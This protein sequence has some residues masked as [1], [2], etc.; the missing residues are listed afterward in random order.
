MRLTLAG[1]NGQETFDAARVI[2]TVPFTALRNIEISPALPPA[3]QRMIDELPYTQIAKTFVLTQ[4]RFWQDDVDFSILFS[5]SRF[6][7]L[8]NL[9]RDRTD[10][11]GLLL[12]WINGDGLAEFSAMSSDAHTDAVVEWLRTLWPD[13]ADQ[14]VDGVTVNWGNTY[15]GGAYAHFAPGQ[16]QAFATEIPKP[17]GSLHFAGEHTELVAPGLEG[18]VVSGQRAAAEVI[19]AML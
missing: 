10:D 17:I 12:N 5:D 4:R 8:F 11:R 9:S 7:R 13:A 16:L 3:R 1:P 18:A 6:E 19:A 15:A 2:V 14:F